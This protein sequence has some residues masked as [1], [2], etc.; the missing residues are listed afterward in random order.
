MARKIIESDRR[1]GRSYQTERRNLDLFKKGAATCSVILQNFASFVHG[2]TLNIIYPLADV[3]LHTFLVGD[4][5]GF[6]DRA[7]LFKPR[8]LLGQIES[9]ASALQFMHAELYIDGERS[10]CAHL[11][12]KPE[13][14]LVFWPTGRI[15]QNT[16]EN[17]DP[18]G[19]WRISDFGLSVIRPR[20][21]DTG[22]SEPLTGQRLAP[23]D[24]AR[25]LLSRERSSMKATRG[26]G[27]WQPP[28]M[29]AGRV[30]KASDLWSF[31]CILATV[32]AFILGGP[33]KV[34]ELLS[35][36]SRVGIYQDDYFYTHT[37][38]PVLK[39]EVLA[40]LNEQENAEQHAAQSH[41][42]RQT[43]HLILDLLQIDRKARGTAE[44]TR[45]RVSRIKRSTENEDS[46]WTPRVGSFQT[47]EVTDAQ[48][49][50][51]DDVES[52][53]SSLKEASQ[54]LPE[55]SA[56]SSVP[57]IDRSHVAHNRISQPDIDHNPMLH[58]LRE[59]S[60]SW[61]AAVGPIAYA[62]LETPPNTIQACLS[63]NGKRAA[64]LS[65]ARVFLF[66]LDNL[67]PLQRPWPE[68]T[69]QV[70]RISGKSF[71][72]SFREFKPSEGRYW[73]S[74]ILAGTFTALC[75][76]PSKGSDDVRFRTQFL[77]TVIC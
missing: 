20:K 69:S 24:I 60:M 8:H 52:V 32:F 53:G 19:L 68:S 6:S 65:R 10:E 63:S 13:N 73:T 76:A 72:R 23:G 18:A 38:G 66:H 31:G 37:D 71:Q 45:D 43:R 58:R 51:P 47:Q 16:R 41:W 59:A 62:R 40:W 1:G 48:H 5:S 2:S 56:D 22:R 75:S 77:S 15:P 14:V 64:F 39:P 36:R 25:E 28:E 49:S 42:I 9:L 67:A 4:Y 44:A 12:L 27:P 33:D 29:Q 50:G 11:D 34:V 35:C 3:D 54:E 57:D 46:M 26:P 61:P 74:A 30:T 21:S 55:R 70:E 17:N 7:A